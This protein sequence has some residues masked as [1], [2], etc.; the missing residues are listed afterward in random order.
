[1]G[2]A[3][4]SFECVAIA[5]SCT[6]SAPVRGDG[7]ITKRNVMFVPKLALWVEQ[8]KHVNK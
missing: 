3:L 5:G 6:V 7:G 4:A 8:G 1:M 2:T